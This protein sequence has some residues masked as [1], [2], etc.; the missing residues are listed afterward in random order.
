CRPLCRD[1]YVLLKNDLS[2]MADKYC[3]FAGQKILYLYAPFQSGLDLEK[4]VQLDDCS[5]RHIFENQRAL[6]IDVLRRGVEDR[7]L[8]RIYVGAAIDLPQTQW[9]SIRSSAGYARYSLLCFLFCFQ[10]DIGISP[11]LLLFCIY[12]DEDPFDWSVIG[13]EQANVFNRFVRCEI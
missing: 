5:R 13:K 3:V 4:P 10:T 2:S 6:R 12:L 9:F 11:R 7:T 1:K 8:V